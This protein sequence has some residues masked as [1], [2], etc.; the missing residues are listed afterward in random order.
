M[1]YV[2]NLLQ[3]RAADAQTQ[4]SPEAAGAPGG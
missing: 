4:A 3:V 2:N 1:T